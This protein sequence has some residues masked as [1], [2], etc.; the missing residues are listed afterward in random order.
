MIFTTK[1]IYLGV[2]PKTSKKTGKGYLMAKFMSAE[3]SI[4]EF[5]INPE[6]VA[7]VTDLGKMQQFAQ[8][9]VKLEMTSYQGN[10]QVDI[11]GVQ[12]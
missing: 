7:L 6:K 2:E 12:I 4:F 10:I 3:N 5:Y 11:V 8:T 9:G 1:M